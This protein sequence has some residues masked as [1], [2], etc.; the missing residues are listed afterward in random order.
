MGIIA[1][2]EALAGA[3]RANTAFV[4]PIAVGIQAILNMIFVERDAKLAGELA[5]FSPGGNFELY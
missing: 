4:E 3:T 5:R 2:L 1:L